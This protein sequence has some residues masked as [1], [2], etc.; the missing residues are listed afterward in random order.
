[1]S[2]TEV[3]YEDNY[4]GSEAVSQTGIVSP[5]SSEA[6]Q[7]VINTL[8]LIREAH[9]LHNDDS[10]AREV[11][12]KL[13]IEHEPNSELEEILNRVSEACFAILQHPELK[14]W[15]DG[16]SELHPLCA[17]AQALKASTRDLNLLLPSLW[18]AVYQLYV[19][20]GGKSSEGAGQRKKAA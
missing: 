8:Q 11:R 20:V 9:S 16:D 13:G 2:S 12:A 3:P 5:V 6:Q 15:I 1:M 19:F 4:V 18:G 17:R 7:H 14:Q 10:G